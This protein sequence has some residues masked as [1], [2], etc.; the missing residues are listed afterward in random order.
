M[1]KILLIALAGTILLGA[2][3]FLVSHK[4]T[5]SVQIT[6]EVITAWKHF[7]QTY[8]KKFS[9]PD[10][11]VYRMEIFAQNLEVVKAD[12]TGTYGVTQFFDL[13]PE[14]FQSTYLTLQVN[15]ATEAVSDM[16][17]ASDINWVTA[18]KVTGVKNQG[19]CGSC[20]AFSTTGAV[21]SALIL[22]GAA[23]NTLDLSEQQLVDCSKANSGCNGGLMDSAFKYIET[24]H[25]TTEKNYSYTAKDG[26]CVSSKIKSP[27]YGVKSFTD[28]GTST[29]ALA[30][31]LQK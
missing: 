23:N 25:I 19:S 29:T 13:S 22:A 2:T 30:A 21:E 16:D 31:A 1:N 26:S 12:T 27:L 4:K 5:Q 10:M 6:D 9:D 11:E 17:T 24:A 7:K 3:A 8:N 20:W 28:V 14:E 15:N 18:G